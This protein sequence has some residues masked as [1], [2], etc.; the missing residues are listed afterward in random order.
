MVLDGQV[1]EALHGTDTVPAA[2]EIAD[3]AMGKMLGQPDG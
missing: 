1:P 2:S 3:T